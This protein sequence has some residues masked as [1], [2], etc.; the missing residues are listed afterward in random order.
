MVEAHYTNK[1]KTVII[2]NNKGKK[3]EVPVDENNALYKKIIQEGLLKISK[4]KSNK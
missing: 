3:I 2:L 1:E 4:K